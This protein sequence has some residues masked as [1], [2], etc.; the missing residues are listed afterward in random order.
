VIFT[1]ILGAISLLTF[2]LVVQGKPREAWK[3]GS[4]RRVLIA[5]L[6]A[7]TLYILSLLLLGSRDP[8]EIYGSVLNLIS[9]LTTAGFST[10]PLPEVGPA[11]V[12]LLVAMAAGG[13]FGSTAGGLKLARIAVM[14]RTISGALR[15]PRLPD[16][17]FAPL[18]H[19]AKPVQG[20]TLVS[21]LALLCLYI[22]TALLVWSHFLAHGH[23]ALAALVDTISALSTVGLSTGV[24]GAH[25]SPDLMLSLSFAMWLGRLEF[26]AVLVLLIP[27]TWLRGK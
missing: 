1:C 13:D 23:P 4:I 17:A 24:V 19:K 9:G 12:I 18:R 15:A 6:I 5:T 20:D 27:H 11:L 8:Q 10:G 2:V 14:L 26:V 3:L 22:M 25:L 21:I 16:G 7:V